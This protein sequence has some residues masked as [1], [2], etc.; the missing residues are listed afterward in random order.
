YLGPYEVE[1]RTQGGSYKLKELDGT[2]IWK[3]VTAFQLYPYIS[4]NG[5]EFQKLIQDSNHLTDP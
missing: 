3:N 1:W 2:F 5:P 4:R